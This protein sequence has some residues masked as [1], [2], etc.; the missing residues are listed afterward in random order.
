M[1]LP[2]IEV[3]RPSNGWGMNFQIDFDKKFDVY[4]DHFGIGDDQTKEVQIV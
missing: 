4:C 1:G 3:K 2:S